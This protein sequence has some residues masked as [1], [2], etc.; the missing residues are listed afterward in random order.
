MVIIVLLNWGFVYVCVGDS[1]KGNVCLQLMPGVC[2]LRGESG[3]VNASGK[4]YMTCTVRHDD[5]TYAL[6]LSLFFYSLS[7]V[8]AFLFFSFPRL[9]SFQSDS[10]LPRFIS[11]I[12]SCSPHYF[13]SLICF[14]HRRNPFPINLLSLRFHY[15]KRRSDWILC[16]CRNT[17]PA[18]EPTTLLHCY[19]NQHCPQGSP[20]TPL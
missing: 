6:A 13:L 11:A 18:F 4:R 10:L 20:E 17:G 9:C 12:Y 15:V 16:A 8:L 19:Y 14:S 7:H 1:W 5:I 2:M 3:T